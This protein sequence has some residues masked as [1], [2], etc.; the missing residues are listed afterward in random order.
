MRHVNIMKHN[1]NI[2][3]TDITTKSSGI[4]QVLTYV[5]TTLLVFALIFIGVLFAFKCKSK[6]RK[7]VSRD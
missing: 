1:N 3:L 6:Y 4:W 7:K 5:L 2:Y